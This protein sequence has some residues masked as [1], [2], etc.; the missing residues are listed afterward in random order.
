MVS[1]SM[2][3]SLIPY[4]AFCPVKNDMTA[5]HQGWTAFPELRA[6]VCVMCLPKLGPEIESQCP[7]VVAARPQCDF[8]TCPVLNHCQ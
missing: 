4:C 7:A 1:C 2:R 8:L 5:D 6:E 3:G